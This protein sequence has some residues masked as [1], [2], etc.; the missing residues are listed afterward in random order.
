MPAVFF[1]FFRLIFRV[2]HF[3][4]DCFWMNIKLTRRKL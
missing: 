2:V 3:A 1:I 4:Y